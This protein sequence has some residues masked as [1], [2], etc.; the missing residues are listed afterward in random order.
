MAASTASIKAYVILLR[1]PFQLLLSPIFL[2]G[3]LL[4]GGT[5]NATLFI[6]YLAFHL[7]G[8]AG[9]TALNSFYDRDTGPIGGLAHPPPNP[10]HL[11]AFSLVWQLVGFIL[12]LAVNFTVAA[13]Y[14]IMFFMSLAYS[15]PRV[16]LKGK[17]IAALVTV[18]LGQGILPFYAGWA[19][20]RGSLEGGLGFDAIVAAL[21]ATLIIGGMYPLTQIYQL[22]ADA[23][24][25]D[26]TAA[27]FLGVTNS[28][29]LAALCMSIGGAGAMYIAA[30]RFS[31]LE[32]LGLAIFILVLLILIV[33]WQNHFAQQTVMQNFSTLMRLYAGVTL[34]FLAW[35]VFHL[36]IATRV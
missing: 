34:P 31:M 10:P 22:D 29:R 27:R 4:A 21:A 33:R 19:T 28:F 24:R 23:A 15:Y 36:W 5:L 6:S 30:T 17:P 25:G 18:M 16:R 3:V 32:A 26:L 13:I 1:L 35:I 14:A 20:A 9:G 12:V 2:W 7:F 8:Y 11:L